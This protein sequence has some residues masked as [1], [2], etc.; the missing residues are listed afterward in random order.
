MDQK[1]ISVRKGGSYIVDF[2][3]GEKPF[4]RIGDVV[5]GLKFYLHHH[6]KDFGKCKPEIHSGLDDREDA[7]LKDALRGLYEFKAK[8]L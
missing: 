6:R 5:M 7:I 4:E 1:P 8:R 3:D 2:P